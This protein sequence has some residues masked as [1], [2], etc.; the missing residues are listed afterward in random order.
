LASGRGILIA[1]DGGGA[2]GGEPARLVAGLKLV[3]PFDEGAVAGLADH[4]V[5]IRKAARFTSVPLKLEMPQLPALVL[6][7]IRNCVG[8]GSIDEAL[9]LGGRLSAAIL[10]V[11][12]ERGGVRPP[13]RFSRAALAPDPKNPRALVLPLTGARRSLRPYHV[14]L[15]RVLDGLPEKLPWPSVTLE[16]LSSAKGTAAL[17]GLLSKSIPEPDIA[18]VPAKLVL[19]R[20]CRVLGEGAEEIGCWGLVPSA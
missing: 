19:I 5:R 6:V 10:E 20:Q 17:H 11:W 2:A 18:F 3:L 12:G 15:G 8:V 16:R 14:A 7:E 1:Q 9:A 13:L 4:L